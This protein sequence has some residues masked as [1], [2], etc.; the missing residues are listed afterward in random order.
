MA[1]FALITPFPSGARFFSSYLGE[2]LLCHLPAITTG[3]IEGIESGIAGAAGCLVACPLT[4]RQLV[5]S[6][7][8][9]VCPRIE[10]AV[11]AARRRGAEVIGLCP[12]AGPL[13]EGVGNRLGLP[14]TNGRC[15]SIA[16]TLAAV[17]LAVR[18]R[19]RDTKTAVAI[20]IGAD[21]PEGHI[22]AGL[23]AREVQNLTLVAS[24]SGVMERLAYRIVQDCGL[25]VHLT[26][27][28]EKVIP[29]ADI[30]LAPDP[31]GVALLKPGYIKTGAVVCLPG[32]PSPVA[33]TLAAACPDVT[34]LT[35]GLVKIPGRV[36]GRFA[37]DLPPGLADAWMAEAILLALTDHPEFF[38]LTRELSIDGVTQFYTLGLS[39]GFVPAGWRS[40]QKLRLTI[41]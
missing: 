20:V 5:T 2:K 9:F 6:S 15:A 3:S 31:A 29:G 39:Q 12:P 14:V 19:S 18:Q 21:A 41:F 4:D 25:A 1:C 16:G 24:R 17:K 40:G 26:S 23:L 32:A 34:V 27:R 7:R 22:W 37:P 8:E 38:L 28:W 36:K 33:R 11:K 13:A 30:I 35:D 10:R